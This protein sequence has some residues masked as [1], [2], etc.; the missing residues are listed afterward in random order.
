MKMRTRSIPEIRSKLSALAEVVPFVPETERVD[1][2][3]Y[4]QAKGDESSS[5]FAQHLTRELCERYGVS[6]L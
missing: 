4:P 1:G 2:V 5:V 3:E 6:N